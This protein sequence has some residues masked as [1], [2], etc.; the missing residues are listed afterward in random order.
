[1]ALGAGFGPNA[2]LTINGEAATILSNGDS[3]PGR[4]AFRY[5]HDGPLAGPGHFRQRGFQCGLDAG[6]G[7]LSGHLLGE[8]Q[9]H[10]SGLNPKQ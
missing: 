6:G 4:G 9:R 1:V 8:W 2:Q 3:H 7:S 10:G 5:R